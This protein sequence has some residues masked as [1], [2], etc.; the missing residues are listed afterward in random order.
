MSGVAALMGALLVAAGGPPIVAVFDIEDRG[1]KLNRDT[2][3]NLTDYL[4]AKLTASGSYHVIP[5]EQVRDRLRSQKAE[6]Y[7][8]CYDQSCQIEIGKELAAGKS[9]STKLL[10]IGKTC[11]VTVSVYDLASAATEH[12]AT[13]EG[14]CDEEGVMVSIQ[15]TVDTLVK[16]RTIGAATGLTP[17]PPP[18]PRAEAHEIWTEYFVDNRRSWRVATNGTYYDSGLGAREYWIETKNDRCSIELVNLGVSLPSNFD[19]TWTTTWR[20]G[21]DNSEYGLAIGEDIKN[22]Y[23]F[24]TSGNGWTYAGQYVNRE[25][26][27]DP[28]PWN[29]GTSYVGNGSNSNTH[30]LEV[31]GSRMTY[32]TNGRELMSKPLLAANI[33]GGKIGWSVCN[34]Q[35]ASI[36]SIVVTAHP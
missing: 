10:R 30:K 15:K 2:V 22:Y 32:F 26:V 12:A 23:L 17:P 13:H 31:R 6:S 24:A 11:V 29:K 35:R 28:M 14:K 19:V 34:K 4:A 9:I 27:N 33:R 25:H 8:T 18:P 1:A 3:S 5:N 7:K 21:A 36:S 20:K 16:P